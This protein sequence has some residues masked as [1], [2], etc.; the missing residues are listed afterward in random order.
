[1]ADKG[2]SGQFVV[3]VLCIIEV[4]PKGSGHRQKLLLA[5]LLIGSDNLSG[6]ELIPVVDTPGANIDWQLRAQMKRELG[7]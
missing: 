5:Q 1:V 3:R 2:N 7:I 4:K 6:T